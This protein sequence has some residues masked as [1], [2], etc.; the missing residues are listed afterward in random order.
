LGGTAELDLKNY[1]TDVDRLDWL[2]WTSTVDENSNTITTSNYISLHATLTA[3]QVS[4]TPVED[5]KTPRMNFLS[6]NH[7]N[8]FNPTTTIRF[9]LKRDNPVSLRVYDAAGRLV[10][11][12]V[13]DVLGAGIYDVTWDGTSEN[14]ASAAS[15]VYFYRIAAGDF[16]QNRKMVLLR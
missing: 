1:W 4:A 16:V 7:P 5:D 8:P 9:A 12:L 13:D 2:P 14:G 11:T 15:G 10:R 3:G 6:Q